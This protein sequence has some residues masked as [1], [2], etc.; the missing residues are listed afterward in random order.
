[1]RHNERVGIGRPADK[2]RASLGFPAL[3]LMPWMLAMTDGQAPHDWQFLDDIL[4][5]LGDSTMRFMASLPLKKMKMK[6]GSRAPFAPARFRFEDVETL[7]FGMEHPN[8][9]KQ[10]SIR[11]RKSTF[12]SMKLRCSKFTTF[13][14]TT[15][16]QHAQTD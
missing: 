2:P 12:P 13:R 4:Y 7:A 6:I 9:L 8:A 11:K 15:N 14:L 3:P 1:M 10:K 16:G 5:K